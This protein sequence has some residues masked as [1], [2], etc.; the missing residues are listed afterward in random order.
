MRH[1]LLTVAG[2]KGSTGGCVRRPWSGGDRR[3]PVGELTYAAKCLCSGAMQSTDVS[4]HPRQV[5]THGHGAR[6]NDAERYPT[7]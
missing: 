5:M 6:P 7:R 3:L 4:A 1:R 2:W